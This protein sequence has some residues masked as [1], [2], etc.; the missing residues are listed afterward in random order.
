VVDATQRGECE[1]CGGPWAR[2]PSVQSPLL[3]A[4]LHPLEGKDGVT[5]GAGQRHRTRLNKEGPAFVRVAV[6]VRAVPRS[7]V[8]A[9]R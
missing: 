6:Y 8:L 4:T 2:A 1:A 9:S 7:P 3:P 5:P